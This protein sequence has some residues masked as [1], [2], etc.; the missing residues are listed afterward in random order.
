METQLAVDEVPAVDSTP[1]T[2]QE[3]RVEEIEARPLRRRIGRLAFVVALALLCGLLVYCLTVGGLYKVSVTHP[4]IAEITGLGGPDLPGPPDAPAPDTGVL[5]M[6]Q[7]ASVMVN[8]LAATFG[9]IVTAVV[10]LITLRRT[11]PLPAPPP[12]ARPLAEDRPGIGSAVEAYVVVRRQ[13]RA[14]HRRPPSRP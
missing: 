14:S 12:A 8:S 9:T 4:H 2:S 7:N 5:V 3:V 11:R 13:P 1:R 6:M 10:A